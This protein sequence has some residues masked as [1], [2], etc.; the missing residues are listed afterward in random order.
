LSPQQLLQDQS[1][2]GGTARIYDRIA[3][4]VKR[5]DH[6]SA[7]TDVAETLLQSTGLVDTSNIDP[8][9]LSALIEGMR[10]ASPNQA[11][12]LAG[13]LYKTADT[14]TV[15]QAQSYKNA[16]DAM[17][18]LTTWGQRAAYMFENM[19]THL[20]NQP[21]AP[22]PTRALPGMTLDQ[23]RVYALSNPAGYARR[24]AASQ[25]GGHVGTGA[26]T[27]GAGTDNALLQGIAVRNIAGSLN[28]AGSDIVRDDL[29]AAQKNGVSAAALLAMQSQESGF[30]PNAVS[31]DGG[32]GL[33]QFTDP[34]V[35]RKYLH[36]KPGQDWHAAA[37]DPKRAA[38][39][40]AEYLADLIKQTHGNE[41]AALSMYNGG[42]H[43][44]KAALAYGA[45]VEKRAQQTADRL[46]VH[47]DVTVH[48]QNGQRLPHTINQRRTVTG[49]RTHGPPPR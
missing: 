37:L 18:S 29:A 43:P 42:V 13:Q 26:I 20:F 22:V 17:Q 48:D 34:A 14:Q 40:Q 45:G 25:G 28:Y 15:S 46:D 11:A 7:G 10:T 24:L 41:Q 30:N 21:P 6:G 1:S 12:K 44:G 9:R 3:R 16:A 36:V 33:A 47:V 39:G 8:K 49:G 19:T 4:L 27:Y 5:V 23:T 31:R 32:Y 35:A 38:E 2:R